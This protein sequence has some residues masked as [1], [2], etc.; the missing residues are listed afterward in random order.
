MT[1]VI[2]PSNSG[3]AGMG[4]LVSWM[5]KSRLLT[6]QLSTAFQK[7]QGR[8]KRQVGR[9]QKAKRRRKRLGT[10]KVAWDP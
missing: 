7:D 4:A 8:G 2:K 10:S 9:Q 1:K 5:L 3:V 6:T